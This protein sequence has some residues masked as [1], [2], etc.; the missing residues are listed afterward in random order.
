[1]IAFSKLRDQ[2]GDRLSPKA[3]IFT[4]ATG[5]I[6]WKLFRA[7]A[8]SRKRRYINCLCMSCLSMS[9]IVNVI[10]L[11][12]C[13]QIQYT[14]SSAYRYSTQVVVHTYIHMHTIAIGSYV[15]VTAVV[16]SKRV[17]T[18]Q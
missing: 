11:Q 7:Q 14:S 17:F 6:I 16:L 18:V 5:V 2:L 1:M 12:A 4:T 9:Y 13:I 10:H 8:A 3:V 15:N